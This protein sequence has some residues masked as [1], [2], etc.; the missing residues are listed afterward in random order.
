MTPP[1]QAAEVSSNKTEAV[2]LGFAPATLTYQGLPS[3]DSGTL[4]DSL[5]GYELLQEVG[6]A[7][8]GVVYRARQVQLNRMVALKMILAG[9]HA[10]REQLAR[11]RA[12]AEAIA[13]SSIRISFRS[14]KSASTKACPISRWNLSTKAVRTHGVAFDLT[15]N[16]TRFVS[17]GGSTLEIWSQ[18]A[19]RPNVSLSSKDVGRVVGKLPARFIL[20]VKFSPDGR[21]I[22]TGRGNKETGEVL[23]CDAATGEIH[24]TLVGL[25]GSGQDGGI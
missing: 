14:M 21:H 4:K 11:F 8:M 2:E 18:M 19:G 20:D 5:G 17:G 15:S 10:D 22:A 3:H 16:G 24:H 23:I 9:G 7:G 25:C 12:E 13:T 6:R 1:T